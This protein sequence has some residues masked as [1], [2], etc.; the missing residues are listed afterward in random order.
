MDKLHFRHYQDIVTSQEKIARIYNYIIV[1]KVQ[2][3]I[4]MTKQDYMT[5]ANRKSSRKLNIYIKVRLVR[6]NKTRIYVE[7]NP[8]VMILLG[9]FISK[10][11]METV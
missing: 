9:I 7:K 11:W 5:P 3:T 6:L 8:L 10:E 4:S 1:T 2:W